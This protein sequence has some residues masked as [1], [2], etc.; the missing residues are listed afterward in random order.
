MSGSV[1]VKYIPGMYYSFKLDI[2]LHFMALGFVVYLPCI[3]EGTTRLKELRMRSPGLL[4]LKLVCLVITFSRLGINRV[5]LVV[6]PARGQLN[7][8][9]YIFFPIPDGALEFGL[10]R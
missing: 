10:V 7:R 3:S 1:F 6:N 8:A 5:W 4:F 2:P 9:T